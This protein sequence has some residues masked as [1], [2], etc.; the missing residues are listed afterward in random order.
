MNKFGGWD[1]AVTVCG[2]LGRVVRCTVRVI[3]QFA[4][5]VWLVL[6]CRVISVIVVFV[7]AFFREPRQQTDLIM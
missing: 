2:S 7:G 3:V 5:D 4:I 1:G 6:M